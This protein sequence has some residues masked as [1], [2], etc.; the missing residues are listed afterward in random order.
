MPPQQHETRGASTS[1]PEAVPSSHDADADAAVDVD[2]NEEVASTKSSHKTALRSVPLVELEL[3]NVTYAPMTS[4][5]S[6]HKRRRNKKNTNRKVILDNVSTA[7]SP[8]QLSAWMGP[9]GSGKT[10]LITVAA[11]LYE[12]GD[13]QDGSV[14]KVNDDEG[15][16]PKR[17]TGVVW[18]DDLLLGNLTVEE[19]IYF[20]AKLKT[21]STTP[22]AQVHEVVEET[23]EELGLLHIRDSLIGSTT[24]GQRGISGGERKRVSV[25]SELVVNPSVLFLD[26]PTVSNLGVCPVYDEDALPYHSH[27]C[28]STIL[29]LDSTPR[30][31]NLSCRH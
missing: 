13:L 27:F 4:T 12:K 28:H 20:S 17:L 6:N 1:D 2:D 22:D 16:I 23:M 29:S 5:A 7:V 24:S 21:P 31:H 25:A 9:S 14:I 8:Y 3:E 10:S 15:S 26:E 30:R 18:Q 11:S 19:T